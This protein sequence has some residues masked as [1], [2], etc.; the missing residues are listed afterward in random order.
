MRHPISVSL[1]D[2]S[3][4]RDQVKMSEEYREMTPEQAKNRR[5][6]RAYSVN[7][8]TAP[9][10]DS[11][12]CY[13]AAVGEISHDL[14]HFA[15]KR[16]GKLL[17]AMVGLPARGKTYIAK[18]IKRHLEW[19]GIETGIYNAGNYRRAVRYSFAFPLPEAHPQS[20]AY[21]APLQR[22]FSYIT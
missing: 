8:G 17:L 3:R 20:Q 11:S 9:N 22:E 4:L 2:R 6:R 15:M 13:R 19:M 18:S 14:G 21:C 10:G 5:V 1:F 7:C 12:T 16:D